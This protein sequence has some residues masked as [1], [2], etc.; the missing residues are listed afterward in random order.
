MPLWRV[1]LHQQSIVKELLQHY[2]DHGLIEH[3]DSPYRAATVLVAKSNVSNSCNVTDRFRLVVD[4]RFLIPVI[5]DSGWPSPSLQQCLDS[6]C[7]SLFVSS[8]DFNSGYH[9]IPCV[10][11]VKPI[12]AFS[13]GYGFS[14]WT[15]NVMLQGIKP[16]SYLFQW[17]MEQT[18]S[19]LSDCILPPFYDDV[20]NKGSD[21]QQHLSNVRRVLNRIRQSG[22]TLNALKCKFFQTALPY[23]GHIIE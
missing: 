11:R 5:K 16:T 21:F 23:L 3:I 12:I 17:T 9:Q 10:A 1:P 20:V 7:G 18:F 14:Q 6:V 13:P 2:K 19:D 8:I 15:W 4:Y 22:L